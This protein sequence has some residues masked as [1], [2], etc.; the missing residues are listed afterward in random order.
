MVYIDLEVCFES[1]V[2][3]FISLEIVE[4]GCVFIFIEIRVYILFEYVWEIILDIC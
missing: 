3:V 4:D 2:G 1:E